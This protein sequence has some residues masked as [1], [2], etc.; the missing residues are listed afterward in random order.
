MYVNT[1]LYDM[2]AWIIVLAAIERTVAVML[3]HKYKQWFTL[4]TVSFS[5]S[6]T[7]SFMNIVFY[8]LG[9]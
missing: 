7:H 9:V 3:P 4:K 6:S 5:Y 1:C 2:S 8:F